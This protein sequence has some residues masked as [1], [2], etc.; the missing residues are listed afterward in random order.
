[1]TDFRTQEQITPQLHVV[2]EGREYKGDHGPKQ[3]SITGTLTGIYD[4]WSFVLD[5]SEGRNND[6]L[7][8]NLDRFTPIQ[9]YH[10]DPLV[11]NG[12][13]RRFLQG[14]ITGLRCLTGDGASNLLFSGF[15]LGKLFDSN[16]KPWIRIEGKTWQQLANTIVDPSWL[17]VGRS[18]GW[19]LQ[20][21]ARG[22]ILLSS[23]NRNP[24]LRAGEPVPLGRIQAERVAGTN[25][26]AYVP[27]IQ[28]EVGETV[29]DTLS[30]YARLVGVA[31]GKSG[32]F[33][34]V[35]AD[36][37]LQIFNPDELLSSTAP[38]FRLQY[39]LDERNQ[40]VQ[41][42][43]FSLDGDG[44]YSSYTCYWTP[45]RPPGEVPKDPNQPN[46]GIFKARYDAGDNGPKVKRYNTFGERE[47]YTS[48]MAQARVQWREKQARYGE[49]AVRY[50]I[51]GH[52]MPTVDGKWLPVTEGVLFDVDDSRNNI[53]GTFM[54]E[55][56]TLRQSDAPSGTKADIV[57]RQVG[58]LGA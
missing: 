31:Q 37:Y 57:L 18:D 54:S 46:F 33:V 22:Q 2:F 26:L 48:R 55:S 35:S 49:F 13:P 4:G 27:P 36:G 28:T 32:C 23:I 40:R 19:G 11:N 41:S 25:Y 1:M 47:A 8:M 52:S 10:A 34:S 5:N 16:V 53:Q 29:Y 3:F 42:A 45:V 44:I 14:V 20:T 58:L 7:K 6:L 12:Q 50:T 17:S 39:H 56:V 30:R 24:F 51:E 15:D 38:R 9:I 43:D 21:D